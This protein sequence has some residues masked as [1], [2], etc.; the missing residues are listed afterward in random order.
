MDRCGC[1][2][3]RVSRSLLSDKPHTVKSHLWRT[4]YD[5]TAYATLYFRLHFTRATL[6][7]MNA[8]KTCVLVNFLGRQKPKTDN[9]KRVKTRWVAM[10]SLMAAR[11][12]GQNSGPIFRRSWT[13]VQR[14]NFARAGVSVVC[15]AVFQL[16]MSCCVPRCCAKCAEI[17]MFWAAKF[18]GERAT[19]ISDRVL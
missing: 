11:W 15:N 6:M 18:R 10:P 1:L 12:V 2:I 9:S 5:K 14:I 7:C 16:T 13:K 8:S 3:M 19:Q 4:P 17:W